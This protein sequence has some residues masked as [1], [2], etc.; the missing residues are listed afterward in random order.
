MPSLFILYF[1]G[2][3]INSFRATLLCFFRLEYDGKIH[4]INWKAI[5]QIGETFLRRQA[6][7]KLRCYGF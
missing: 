7:H 5:I 3:V 4:Q 6:P 2:G 1:F